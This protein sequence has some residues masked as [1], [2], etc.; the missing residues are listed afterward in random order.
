MAKFGHIHNH[1]TFTPQFSD[2]LTTEQRKQASHIITMIMEK[3]CGKVKARAYA[4]GR[5]QRKCF[6]REDVSSPTIQQEILIMSMIID[7]KEGKNVAIADVVGAYLLAQMND[8]VLVK[9][10]GKQT[11]RDHM[12]Y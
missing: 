6:K 3:R 9:V 2:K 7:A 11:C 12:H 10:T 5:K 1:D 4:D 8:Y